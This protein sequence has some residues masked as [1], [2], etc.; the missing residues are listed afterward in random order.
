MT[1]TYHRILEYRCVIVQ[2]CLQENMKSYVLMLTVMAGYV[3]GGHTSMPM[4][5]RPMGDLYQVCLY[6][7]SQ[8][9]TLCLTK[10]YNQMKPRQSV[11]NQ[12]RDKTLVA[13]VAN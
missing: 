1:F 8:Y 4:S 11:S 10:Q 6:R 12:Y 2:L 3:V 9:V 7:S 13:S 5:N